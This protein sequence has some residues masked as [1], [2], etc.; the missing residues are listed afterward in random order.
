MKKKT[1]VIP[2]FSFYADY[3]KISSVVFSL[4]IYTPIRF[5]VIINVVK[6]ENTL[7]GRF[8]GQNCTDWCS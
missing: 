3:D 8:Y 6:H 5:S 7:R 4:F 1:L 2:G